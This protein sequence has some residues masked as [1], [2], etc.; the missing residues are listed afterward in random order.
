[1]GSAA[2]SGCQYGTKAEAREPGRGRR[3]VARKKPPREKDAAS[4]PVCVRGGGF[5]EQA[6]DSAAYEARQA[7]ELRDQDWGTEAEG[8]QADR[9][10]TS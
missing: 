6:T 9:E 5:Q 2:G 4:R 8:G 3:S 1:M 7:V 10:P